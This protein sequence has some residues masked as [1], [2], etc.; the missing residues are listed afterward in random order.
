M[1][2]VGSW[3][4]IGQIIPRWMG[5]EKPGN[6]GNNPCLWHWM[7]FS[8]PNLLGIL[9]TPG[10]V[11]VLLS[12]NWNLPQETWKSQILLFQPGQEESVAIPTSFRTWMRTQ[13]SPG[14]GLDSVLDALERSG[15]DRDCL[16]PSHTS[17]AFSWF[18]IHSGI[19]NRHIN[20]L[21]TPVRAGSV[22][23]RAAINTAK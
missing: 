9:R 7:S 3:R 11:E 15:R 20:D 4:R 13:V 6:S 23:I 5:L 2:G 14:D 17:R 12:P 18:Q 19:S 8:N 21:K 10:D 22:F 16:I 1:G